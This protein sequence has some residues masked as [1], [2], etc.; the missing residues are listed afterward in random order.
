M[1]P[2]KGPTPQKTILQVL[3]TNALA[4]NDKESINSLKSYIVQTPAYILSRIDIQVETRERLE[5]YD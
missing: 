4:Y 5:Q 1:T 2:L 3:V